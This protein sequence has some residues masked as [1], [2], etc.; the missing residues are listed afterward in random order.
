MN[1]DWRNIWESGIS[2]E[3]WTDVDYLSKEKAIYFRSTEREQ[4]IKLARYTDNF[5]IS[6]MS[7]LNYTIEMLQNIDLNDITDD[8][9]AD[10]NCDYFIMVG[11]IDVSDYDDAEIENIINSITYD[12]SDG[13]CGYKKH[14]DFEED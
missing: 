8:S 7:D 12:L 5:K 10:Y 6:L 9:I 1:E 3:G 14:Y 11:R 13:D 4:Q 2:L